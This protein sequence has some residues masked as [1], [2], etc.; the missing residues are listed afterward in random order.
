MGDDHHTPGGET[1]RKRAPSGLD[2]AFRAREPDVHFPTEPASI[3]LNAIPHANPRS[4]IAA[5]DT[6]QGASYHRLGFG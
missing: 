3:E 1:P 2:H 6:H 4:E 5:V